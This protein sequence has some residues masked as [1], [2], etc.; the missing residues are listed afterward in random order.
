[1]R[2]KQT[3]GATKPKHYAL[4]PEGAEPF[5]VTD[6]YSVELRGYYRLEYT[7]VGPEE[8]DSDCMVTVSRGDI[9]FGSTHIDDLEDYLEDIDADEREE[10]ENKMTLKIERLHLKGYAVSIVT[11]MHRSMW[12][13]LRMTVTVADIKEYWRWQPQQS[14]GEY[15]RKYGY[16]RREPTVQPFEAKNWAG[17]AYTR[18]DWPRFPRD[19]GEPDQILIEIA[20]GERRARKVAAAMDKYLKKVMANDPWS[21]MV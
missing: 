21:A 1:M 14:T 11:P 8:G 2:A 18:Y 19:Y 17:R 15:L 16:W 3:N 6:D 10:A 9:D 7:K 20:Q 13:N 12:G 4:L 5:P